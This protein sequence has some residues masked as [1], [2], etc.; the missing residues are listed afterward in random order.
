M[1]KIVD[2]RGDLTKK[3]TLA[4]KVRWL[5]YGEHHDTWEPWR[6]VRTNDALHAY[7]RSIDQEKLI[8]KACITPT[9]EATEAPE[10]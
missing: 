5:G 2:H 10:T 3:S 9:P 6:N 1:D 4:F 8:P 7:L